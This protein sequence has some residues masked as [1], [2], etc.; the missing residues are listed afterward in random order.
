MSQPSLNLPLLQPRSILSSEWDDSVVVEAD[1]PAAEAAEAE[2][3]DAVGEHKL[4][5]DE[6]DEAES[7]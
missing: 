3:T 1:A 5:A 2:I 7:R 6:V 4:P